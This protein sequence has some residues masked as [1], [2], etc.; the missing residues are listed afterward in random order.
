MIRKGSQ[1]GKL[2]NFVKASAGPGRQT[3]GDTDGDTDEPFQSAFQSI[4]GLLAK[5]S[6]GVSGSRLAFERLDFGVD[7]SGR[8]AGL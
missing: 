2:H 4:F 5:S 1:E 6:R 8:A 7:G 3:D